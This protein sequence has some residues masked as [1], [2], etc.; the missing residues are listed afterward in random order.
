MSKPTYDE[1]QAR[2]AELEAAEQTTKWHLNRLATIEK[3]L[4]K[5]LAGIWQQLRMA[6][7]ADSWG[8]YPL[9]GNELGV[10]FSPGQLRP[11]LDPGQNEAFRAITQIPY[12]V[13]SQ[14]LVGAAYRADAAVAVADIQGEDGLP[15]PESQARFERLTAV[16][17]QQAPAHSSL[18]LPL[19]FAG[20]RNGVLVVNRAEVRPFTDEDIAAIQPYAD[21]MALAIGNARAAE[22]LE[23]RNRELAEALDRQAAVA[24]VLEVVSRA[25]SD[26]QA[27]LD[28]IVLRASALL[29]SESSA[30]LRL[31]DGG[32]ER[33]ALARHGVV[34][35]EQSRLDAPTPNGPSEALRENRTVMRHGGPDAIAHESPKTAGILRDA[36]RNSSIVTPLTTTAGP[37]GTLIVSRSSPEPYNASQIALLE[38]F[39]DQAVIAI[40]NARLFN[41]LQE[42]NRKVTEAREREEAT[43]EILR[44][45]SRSPEQLDDTLRA[46]GE[47][48]TVVASETSP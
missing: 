46:V 24:G 9:R 27:A 36:G 23:E 25:P 15:Y 42:R 29:A 35:L 11:D 44:H 45:I 37:F 40:E 18:A 10:I 12:L 20:E 39:A 34:I 28:A 26:L 32:P 16:M 48:A 6:G 3:P 7:L 47:A 2:V 8:A 17:G 4:D 33:V 22:Q 19:R 38:T 30:V 41:E 14:S 43:S 31:A 5:L 1:L 13:D 21:Q